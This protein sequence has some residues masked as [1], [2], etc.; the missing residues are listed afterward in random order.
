[1]FSFRFEKVEQ[2]PSVPLLVNPSEVHP[3]EGGALLI[4]KKKSFNRERSPLIAEYCAFFEPKRNISTNLA[5]EVCNEDRFRSLCHVD[6]FFNTR[7][8]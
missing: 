1:L 7:V 5:N 3:P 6:K 8:D 2:K 4:G